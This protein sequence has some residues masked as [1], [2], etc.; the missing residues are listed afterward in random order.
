MASR[1]VNVPIAALLALGIAGCGNQPEEAPTPPPQTAQTSQVPPDETGAALAMRQKA[2]DFMVNLRVEGTAK[3][4]ENRFIATVTRAGEPVTDA[5]VHVLLT[6]PAMK[7]YGSDVVLAHTET[8]RYEGTA[9][10][11][12]AGDWQANVTVT[13]GEAEGKT[14]YDFRV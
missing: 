4:G 12:M 3:K 6:M 2:G 8:G 7:M 11:S 13:A 9:N 5:T 10:L 1:I 14:V